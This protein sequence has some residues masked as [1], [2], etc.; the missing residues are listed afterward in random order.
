MTCLVIYLDNWQ[1]TGF[2][3]LNDTLGWLHYQYIFTKCLF[4][5][6]IVFNFLKVYFAVYYYFFLIW[7]T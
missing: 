6:P 2:I 1:S 3:S 5:L 4:L 7:V